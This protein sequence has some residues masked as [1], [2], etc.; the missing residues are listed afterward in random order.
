M[1][2]SWLGKVAAGIL[3]LA[4]A[5]SCLLQVGVIGYSHQ[6]EVVLG[7]GITGGLVFLM[8]AAASLAF[9]P[10]LANSVTKQVAVVVV[11]LVSCTMASLLSVLS[12]LRLL[13]VPHDIYYIHYGLAS[14]MCNLYSGLLACGLMA[15]LASLTLLTV[16]CL[17]LPFC[18][19]HNQ[20]GP[21][22]QKKEGQ[23]GKGG[24]T[25]SANNNNGGWRQ[26]L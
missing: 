22:G 17:A 9:A 18:T 4:G 6:Y 12:T 8:A 3:G 1:G 21:L 16:T 25:G 10:T 24:A 11:L 13:A 23:D 15:G 20:V 19:T 26:T 14:L 2:G 5:A 7:E